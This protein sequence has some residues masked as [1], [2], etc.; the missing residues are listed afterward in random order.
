MKT[1]KGMS[2][3]EYDRLRSRSG[4][5]EYFRA[6]AEEPAVE[7]PGDRFTDRSDAG[8]RAYDEC[9][10]ISNAIAAKGGVRRGGAYDNAR[11][12]EST[13]RSALSA[14][15]RASA[16]VHRPGANDPGDDLPPAA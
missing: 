5:R 9:M 6:P 16:Y 7:R 10:D 15:K 12:Y 4:L 2:R 3:Q 14:L 1:V 8:R 13:K 11:T